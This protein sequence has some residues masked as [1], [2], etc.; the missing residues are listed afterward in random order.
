MIAWWAKADKMAQR[1]ERELKKLDHHLEVVFI[2]PEA[3]SL[4]PSERGLGVVPGRW[5]IVRRNPGRID[6][7]F[8]IMGP[9]MEYRDPE[10]AVI[11]D[12]KKADLWRRGALQELRDK[13]VRQAI[14]SERNEQLVREQLR[15]ES[16]LAFRAAKRMPGDNGLHRRHDRK[17]VRPERR[18]KSGLILP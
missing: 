13:Q 12:M 15:D 17:G 5:H 9:N 7:W 1:L 11:E 2:D 6:S 8:P 18:T 10:L 16:A 14:E 3:A 4:P